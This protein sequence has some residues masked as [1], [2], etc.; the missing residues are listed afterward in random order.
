MLIYCDFRQGLKSYFC[1]FI[2]S[3]LNLS[4]CA[5]DTGIT[6]QGEARIIDYSKPDKVTENPSLID[7][8]Q[9]S[10]QG[11]ALVITEQMVKPAV[12]IS[13]PRQLKEA[14]KAFTPLK[15]KSPAKIIPIHKAEHS[16][17]A[18]DSFLGFGSYKTL[19]Q[20]VNVFQPQKKL[21]GKSYLASDYSFI[22]CTGRDE[23]VISSFYSL[24]YVPAS[25]NSIYFAIP[26]PSS[27]M[28]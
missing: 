13:S 4:L 21:F 2:F 10:V 28:C 3:L 12:A 14:V 17:Q 16:F 22:L 18:N 9:L 23:N 20:A 7:V 24:N 6:I 8:N 19:G 25:A 27:L 15:K 1:V 26:P 5:Q 11:K